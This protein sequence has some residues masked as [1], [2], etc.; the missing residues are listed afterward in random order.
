MVER[1]GARI[2]DPHTDLLLAGR[3]HIPRDHGAAAARD[4]EDFAGRLVWALGKNL[5]RRK[6]QP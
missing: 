3:P 2:L 4:V 5:V 6:I 1:L